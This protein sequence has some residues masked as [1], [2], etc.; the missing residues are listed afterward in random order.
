[1]IRII[2]SYLENLLKNIGSEYDEKEDVKTTE[3]RALIFRGLG[4]TCE[5]NKYIDTAKNLYSKYLNDKNSV[6]PNLAASAIAIIAQNGDK[7]LHTEFFEKYT[8]SQIPQEKIR[9]LFSLSEFKSNDLIK[10]TLKLSLS[11]KIKNQDAPYL[12]ATAIRNYR[13]TK[14]AWNFVEQNWEKINKIFPNNTI[15]RMFGGIKSVSDKELAERI[16]LFF[17]KNPVPQGQKTI[18]QNLEKMNINL[19]FVDHQSKILNNWLQDF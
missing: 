17:D 15:P 1:M 6:E 2:D 12:I 19:K 10:E 8:S 13:H 11:E 7:D 18:D 4:I 14:T 3:L 16:S 5:N 9:F